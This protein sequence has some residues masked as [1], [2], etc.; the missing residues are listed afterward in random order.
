M[1]FFYTNKNIFED[2][3]EYFDPN[4]MDSKTIVTPPKKNWDYKRPLKIEDIDIW[5]GLYVGNVDVYAAWNPFAEFYLVKPKHW[6][7][8]ANHHLQTFY[9]P[10]AAEDTYIYVKELY[11]VSLPI[12][13][14]W[15]E[16][17]DIRMSHHNF[18]LEQNK[19]KRYNIGQ[20][21]INTKF[22]NKMNIKI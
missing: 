14:V 10:S 19:N 15:V 8:D 6:N 5:E 7:E 16:K 13:K 1:P 22:I 12:T 3:G 18:V 9:G 11:N 2:N 21:K 20:N 17:D 4:W